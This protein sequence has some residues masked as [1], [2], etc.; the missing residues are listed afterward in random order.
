[1]ADLKTY[2]DV[3]LKTYV[4]TDINYISSFPREFITLHARY[5]KGPEYCDKC[6]IDGCI[7]GVFVTYC[8]EHIQQGLGQQTQGQIQGQQIQAQG[9]QTQAQGQ[10]TQAQGL[11]RQIYD[12]VMDFKEKKK[13]LCE[14]FEI[15]TCHDLQN[16]V[17][18][19]YASI[20]AK[21]LVLFCEDCD[22]EIHVENSSV[23]LSPLENVRCDKCAAQRL[24]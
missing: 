10:Q 21:P 19:Y 3:D 24:V 9:Q 18:R 13:E 4:H 2:A 6:H 20:V 8:L 11:G 14:G 23:Y 15:Y 1:M 17:Q 5:K 16:Y 12:I 7:N 22:V